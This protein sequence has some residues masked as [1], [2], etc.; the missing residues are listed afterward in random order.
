MP[1]PTRT[2]DPAR[3]ARWGLFVLTLVN[4]FNYLDRQVLAALFESL[5][6]SELHLSDA[7]LGLLATAFL[8][9]Y[10]LTSPIFGTLGDRGNR[11]RL[12]GVGPQKMQSALPGSQ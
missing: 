7:Q 12:I 1:A 11:P 8:L 9:V 4:T 5:K 3:V 10:M 2:A 6:H